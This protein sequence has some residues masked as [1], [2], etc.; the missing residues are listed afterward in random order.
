MKFNKSVSIIL[1]L[2]V[3]FSLS[4]C[5]YKKIQVS[6][7]T[8]INKKIEVSITP[9]IYEYSATMSSTP[10]I[11][12]TAKLNTNT[13]EGNIQFHWV[14]EEGTFLDWKQ[15]NGKVSTLG[16]DIKSN[17]Q[18]VY[19]SVDPKEKLKK[20]S[21]QLYLKIEEINSSKVISETSVQIEQNA[22]GV[23]SIKK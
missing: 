18:K 1:I 2:G 22:A 9:E 5:G 10:G 16:K 3:F 12:L 17:Q 15:D 11:P 6:P 13:N 20:T 23:F 8:D 21:F 14:T 19:W 4:G 7:K